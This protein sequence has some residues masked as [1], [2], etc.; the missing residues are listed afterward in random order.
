MLPG[1]PMRSSNGKMNRRGVWRIRIGGRAGPPIKIDFQTLASVVRP[2]FRALSRAA[3]GWTILPS[4]VPG[5]AGKRVRRLKA[6]PT[7]SA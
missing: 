2:K 1:L 7:K 3:A 5:P 6:C 4:R